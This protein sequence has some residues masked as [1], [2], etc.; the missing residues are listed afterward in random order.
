MSKYKIAVFGIVALVALTGCLNGLGGDTGN[1]GD[2]V[3][4][5]G[6]ATVAVA[7]GLGAE[8]Q[9]NL[10]GMINQSEQRLLQR[11]QLAPGNLSQ[12]EQQRAQEIQTE[13]QEAQQQAVQESADSFRSTVEGTETL[14]VQ[15]SIQQGSSTLFLV[16]GS[17]SEIVALLEQD[18]VQALASESQYNQLQ[19]QQQQAPGGPGGAPAPEP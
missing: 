10:T 4:T 12:E 6:N 1:G 15:D 11:A 14:V 9:Q 18:G 3:E 2:G 17:P 7:V 13:M 8:A 19:Q 16:S 5:S